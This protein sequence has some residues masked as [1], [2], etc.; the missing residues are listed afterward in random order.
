MK[1]DAIIVGGGLG[2]LSAGAILSRH[3]K[4]VLL[5]EQHYIPGG[6][7][8]TFKRKDFVMEVGLHA[9][10]G[11]LIDRR[12]HQSVLRFL[13][14]KKQLQLEPLPEFFRI[15][16]SS[17]DFTLPHGTGPAQEALLRAFPGEE[18]G[19][20][21]F[22]RL[23]LGV[24]DETHR[25]PK[26]K[27]R[28]KLLSPL[29]PVLFR[30]THKASRTTLGKYLDQYISNDQLKVILQGN[31]IYYHDDPYTMSMAFFA[32]AQAGFIHYGGYFIRGGSQQLSNAL[33]DE[34]RR[35]GGTVLLGKKVV[36][37]LTENGKALGVSYKD[38]FNDRIDSIDVRGRHI[39]FN[40]AVP[41][42]RD[43]LT[44]TSK[45]KI[46]KLVRGLRPACALFNVYIG[47][48]K[49]VKRI[50]N[51]HYSTFIFGDDVQQ[52]KDVHPGNYGDWN[53]RS[54]VFVDY[55]QV[56]SGLAPDG[57][58]FGVICAVDRLSEWENLEEDQ[59][60]EKKEEIAQ[61]LIGR[62]EKAIPGIAGL[63]EYVEAATPLT[64]RRYTLNPSGSPYGYAQIPGQTGK[65]R[66]APQSPVKHLWF[67]GAWTF[68]GGGFTGTIIS[69]F[70]CGLQV[71]KK[72]EKEG[73][74]RDKG[75]PSDQRI[76]KLLKT[77]EVALNTLELSFEKP[78]NFQFQ[79]G[80]YAIVSLNH[81][82]YNNLDVPFRTLS[83]VSHPDEEVLRFVM[84]RSESSFKRSCGALQVGDTATIYGPSGD[85]AVCDTNKGIVFLVAGIGISP[86]MPM[87]KELVKRR[88]IHPVFLFYS[89]RT[90]EEAAYH[91][92]LRS[93]GL[94]DYHYMPVFTKKQGRIGE[95]TIKKEL[96]DPERYTY[97]IVGSRSF[98]HSMVD[99]LQ[100]LQVP[101][102]HIRL[103]DFG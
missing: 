102:E 35:K 46:D 22:F 92:V 51:R 39:I 60:K 90:E 74:N 70:L 80:Q 99:I 71:M 67:A 7:A 37:V 50:G 65:N 15:R 52:L 61:I 31:L 58:S 5:L 26:E 81:P 4:R 96:A 9:M 88:F 94:S 6:C 49:E 78:C 30:H 14:V 56:D 32:K 83:M 18:Q 2:G 101:D 69:G 75:T 17:I 73:P 59:Y 21:R 86:V 10:D 79:P 8:T 98:L 23:M 53:S 33:A 20:R 24:Q 43:L 27:W 16:N 3:G 57:K 47:F 100:G 68:P 82:V 55:S 40:A 44:G 38:S 19:I 13:G 36:R 45:E 62:L 25:I 103:D 29:F 11:L 48:N 12:S 93:A 87:L 72:L 63:I 95:E 77:G 28:L 66:P 54:F 1:F 64:I 41:T 42:L 34:I 97:Y 84:R 76:V 85:F 89:N 91:R